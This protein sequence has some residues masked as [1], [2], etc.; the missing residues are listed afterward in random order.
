MVISLTQ[1]IIMI[2]SEALTIIIFVR[3]SGAQLFNFTF[4]ETIPISILVL[5]G[6]SSRF[7]QLP[8]NS[9]YIKNTN[10]TLAGTIDGMYNYSEKQYRT[11]RLAYR[12]KNQPNF[13]DTI[14]ID[15]PQ[16]FD[17]SDKL[18]NRWCRVFKTFI[19]IR[20][21]VDMLISHTLQRWRPKVIAQKSSPI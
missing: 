2:A 5:H 19:Q 17:L 11:L 1:V 4:K 12:M 14:Y 10:H 8:A 9:F 7:R 3:N 18:S 21:Q 13:A 20:I 6:W 15:A 16:F